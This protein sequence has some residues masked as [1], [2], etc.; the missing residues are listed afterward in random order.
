PTGTRW[1][2]RRAISCGCCRHRTREGDGAGSL[3]SSAAVMASAPVQALLDR[4]VR[5]VDAGQIFVDADGDPARI[6]P[7]ATIFPGARLHGLR[8]FLGAGVQVGTEGPATL[9]DA[10]LAEGGATARVYAKGVVLL[11]GPSL[12]AAGHTREGTLLEEEASTSH[13]VG[14]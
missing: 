10:V 11:R 3:L 8:T 2:G 5:V 9:V 7:T 12:G 13:G 1:R 14:L 4:G 6:H